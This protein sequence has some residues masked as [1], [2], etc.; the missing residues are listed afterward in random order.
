METTNERPENVEKA[1]K[2]EN[3]PAEEQ[4]E[5]VADETE[6]SAEQAEGGETEE[7]LE[8]EEITTLREA[9]SAAEKLRDEYLQ[10]AQRALA[11]Y[12]NLKKRNT[13]VR[14]EAYDEGVR[15]TIAQVLPVID[16]LERAIGAAKADE[17]GQ[18]I[19][20]GVEMTA[21]QLLDILGKNGLEEIPALGEKF[22]PNVHNAVMRTH[23]EEAEPGQVLEV[24]QKGY[25]IKDRVIR[26]AMVRIAS[27]D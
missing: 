11:D 16:N 9:L 7:T 24:Y 3:Q 18:S 17:N 22:D 15:E 10:M 27:D 12:Q 25:R 23:D 4:P 5:T 14:T 13:A 26:Y 20:S 6:A 21:K 19:L 1:E 8:N 2:V